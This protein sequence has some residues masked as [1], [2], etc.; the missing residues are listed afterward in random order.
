MKKIFLQIISI[1]VLAGCSNHK[2]EKPAGGPCAYVD[3]TY[4]AKLIKLEASPDSSTFNPLFE[5]DDPLIDGMKDTLSYLRFSNQ[6]V[7]KEQLKK[8]S[9]AVGNV[10][11]YIVSTII[12]GACDPDIRRLSL[13]RY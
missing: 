6:S 7:T 5:I 1:A 3:H 4:P 13:E 10:Y 12:E 2:K 9:I 11:K 8:D